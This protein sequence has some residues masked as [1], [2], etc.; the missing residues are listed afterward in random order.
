MTPEVIWTS[1]ASEDYLK[2]DPM[3]A[4]SSAVEGIVQLLRLFP[5]MG[6]SESTRV[7]RVL[8]GR[9]RVYGLFYAPTQTRIVV[10]ALVD[11]R[12]DPDIVETL[13][14]SRGIGS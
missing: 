13:L 4:P 6:S 12:Q 14:R 3:I 11:L 9:R 7:R 5:E 8:V 2:A 10:L 1:G